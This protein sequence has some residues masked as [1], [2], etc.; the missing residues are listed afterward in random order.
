MVLS[1]CEFSQWRN[2]QTAA[3]WIVYRYWDNVAGPTLDAA[4]LNFVYDGTIIVSN[5][6]CDRAIPLTCPS[7]PAEQSVS[8]TVMLAAL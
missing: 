4:L 5:I 2:A 8:I 1:T 7:R 3:D 6:T